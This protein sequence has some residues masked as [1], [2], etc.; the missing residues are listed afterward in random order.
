[1]NFIAYQEIFQQI[2]NDPQPPAPYQDP[3]YL[4]YVKL[5]WSRQQRWL[6]TGILNEELAA[7]IGSIKGE[8]HWT[9]ITEPWCGDAAHSIPFLHRLSELNP[10][11]KVDYQL[12]DSEPFLID[13]YLT[14]GSKSIPKLIVR[15][16]NGNDLFNWGPRPKQAQELL[17]KL[18]AKNADFETIKLELQH[19]YNLDRGESLCVELETLLD[20]F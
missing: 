18:K 15:D 13:Q 14:N 3:D 7:V 5:N 6:K 20:K 1:M 16:S 2:L 4:N 19:W 11:I 12:R 10:L 17:D 9:I 8:Q